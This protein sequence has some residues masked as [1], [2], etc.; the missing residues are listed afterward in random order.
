M[1]TLPGFCF[2]YATNSASVRTGDEALTISTQLVTL[3]PAIGVTSR[4]GS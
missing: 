3:A 4:R 1:L 2:A